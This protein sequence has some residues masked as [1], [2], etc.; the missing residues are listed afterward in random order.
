MRRTPNPLG[1]PLLRASSNPGS[2]AQ[3][4]LNMAHMPWGLPLGWDGLQSA[5]NRLLGIGAMK[6]PQ[7]PSITPSQS[8]TVSTQ[9]Q[10]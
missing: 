7:S 8:W 3:G 6:T 9:G 10:G 5:G 4:T 2:Q 1:Q